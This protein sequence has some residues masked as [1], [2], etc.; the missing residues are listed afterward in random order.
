MT[1]FLL[2]NWF[3]AMLVVSIVFFLIMWCFDSDR[4][5]VGK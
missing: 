5:S 3:P 4:H 1:E 2:D